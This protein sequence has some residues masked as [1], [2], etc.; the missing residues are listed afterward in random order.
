MLTYTL[1]IYQAYPRTQAG[2]TAYRF[3]QA[4]LSRGH[5]IEQVFFYGDAVYLTQASEHAPQDERQVVSL[6]QTLAQTHHIP[7]VF[8]NTAAQWRGVT[9]TAAFEVAGLGQFIESTLKA[10]RVLSFGVPV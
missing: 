7:L 10:E 6:W 9:A 2:Y 4:A 3:A 8:C 1:L 5:V